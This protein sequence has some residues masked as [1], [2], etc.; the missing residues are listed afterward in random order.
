MSTRGRRGRRNAEGSQEESEAS[1]NNSSTDSEGETK[2]TGTPG[3]RYSIDLRAFHKTKRRLETELRN[4]DA[5]DDIMD[6]Y[7][8]DGKEYTKINPLLSGH[9]TYPLIQA[10]YEHRSDGDLN[11]CWGRRCELTTLGRSILEDMQTEEGKEEATETEYGDEQGT[12]LAT[13]TQM[14]LYPKKAWRNFE[15]YFSA[16]GKPEGLINKKKWKKLKKKIYRWLKNAHYMYSTVISRLPTD[17]LHLA[18]GIE[19]SNG[20][21]LYTHMLTRFGQTHAQCLATLLRIITNLALLNPD[22]KTGRTET[23]MDYFDR[24]QRISREAKQFPAMSVPI[25]APLLKVMILEGLVKSDDKYRNMVMA[26]YANNLTTDIPQL[27][28]TMQTVEGLREAEIMERYAPVKLAQADVLMGAGIRQEVCKVFARTNRCRYGDRC[29]YKHDGESRTPRAARFGPFTF[30]GRKDLCRLFT[31]TGKCKFGKA[32]RYK[33]EP[34]LA[35]AHLTEAAQGISDPDMKET[36]ASGNLIGHES[37]DPF[38]FIGQ[39]EDDE[40]SETLDF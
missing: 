1:S 37:A 35:R 2:K 32:C 33:H 5:C 27:R 4:R 24:A 31:T 6:V 22:P 3:K 7:C 34:K 11:T 16:R 39:D 13:P 8:S 23:I 15:R 28:Q 21:Q 9:G 10:I 40:S 29:K 36:E 14:H 19:M 30:K 12:M 25:A 17:G 26:E 18:D 20:P 38:A